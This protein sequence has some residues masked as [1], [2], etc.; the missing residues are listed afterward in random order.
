MQHASEEFY[1][2]RKWRFLDMLMAYR[3]LEATN[4]RDKVYSLLGLLHGTLYGL[5]QD[6]THQVRE[7]YIETALTLMGVDQNLD[8][9]AVP[10]VH[11]TTSCIDL[12]LPS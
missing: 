8:I 5:Q 2:R 10:R 3:N 4:A 6:Y 9:L 1:Y 11:T 7:V 12:K